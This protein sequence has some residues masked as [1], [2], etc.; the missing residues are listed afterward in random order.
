MISTVI[1][2]RCYFVNVLEYVIL[3]F[4][5]DLR[6]FKLASS[7]ADLKLPI[8]GME[9]GVKTKP[10]LLHVVIFPVISSA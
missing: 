9:H 5:M 3:D 4:F 2:S 8:Q 6:Y 10:K 1:N 7:K